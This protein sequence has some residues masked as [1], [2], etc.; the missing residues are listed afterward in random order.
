MGALCQRSVLWL[1]S[2]LCPLLSAP[3]VQRGILET[4][5]WAGREG[6]GEGHS[7]EGGTQ[8]VLLRAGEEGHRQQLHKS[9]VPVDLLPP[10]GPDSVSC[11][12]LCSN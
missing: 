8:A 4:L 5:Y 7:P 6:G 1:P 3:T 10:Q 11:Y 9:L 12:Q 2:A